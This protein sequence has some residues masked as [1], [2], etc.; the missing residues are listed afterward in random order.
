MKRWLTFV[1]VLALA[2]ALGG[3]LS[4]IPEALVEV[5][6]FKV[7]EVRLRGARFLEHEDVVESLDLSSGASVWDDT[8][9]LEARLQEHPLVE[10]VK[11]HRRF[12]DALLV[13]V[14]EKEP[15]AL[16]PSPTLEP[17]DESG[18]IL[19]ID[20]ALH[21]LDLPIMTSAGEG[22]PGSLTPAGR[23]LVAG[24]ISRLAQGDPEFHSRTSDFALYPRG[25]MRVRILDSPVTIQFRPGLSSGRI[26]AGL[27]VLRNAQGRFEEGEVV[28]L[29][30]RFEDQI[31]VRLGR[32]GGT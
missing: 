7:T 6:A 3:M 10:S 20:P 14:V 23:R 19:P 5:E 30:L 29:D 26:Q 13:Q 21:K 24:E 16:Y 4:R 31:V 22:G 2:V 17:V 9:L 27:R 11:I 1:F 15:V 8:K 18:Q 25:D 28:E 32:A 12:P